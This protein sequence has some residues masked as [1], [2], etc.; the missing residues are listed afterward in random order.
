MLEPF[1]NKL[2][3]APDIQEALAYA[4]RG[5][6]DAIILWARDTATVATS[7]ADLPIL[8][9]VAKDERR[10]PAGA[11]QI[12]AWPAQA[13]SLHAALRSV[14]D[15]G[16]TT[17]VDDDE[18]PSKAPL[19]ATAMAALEKSV[20]LKTLV[21]ILQAYVQTSE[22]LCRSLSNAS[23][24][25]DWAEAART[26]QDIAGSAGALGLA[27]MTAAARG[28]ASAARDGE[29]AD[30]LRSLARGLVHEHQLARRALANIYPD[31]AA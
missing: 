10:A 13:A 17:F 7:G 20:G 30:E 1:G 11:R 3:V 21:E 2:T 8:S 19:D 23:E 9:L 22:E 31:L 5:A 14:K 26:A 28:F 4:G 18:E 24:R 6:F 29:N 12:L 15:H 25:A 16:A 27:A